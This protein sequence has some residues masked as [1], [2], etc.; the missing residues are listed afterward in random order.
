MFTVQRFVGFLKMRRRVIIHASFPNPASVPE[1]KQTLRRT[2]GGSE[3]LHAPFN[4]MA[5][6]SPHRGLIAVDAISILFHLLFEDISIFPNWA[7][8]TPVVTRLRIGHTR[9]NAHQHR[10][11]ITDTLQ[12][13]MALVPYTA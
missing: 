2:G 6:Y 11:G 1:D 10:L 5:L 7:L 3:R 4:R 13:P 9:L 12:F 8:E